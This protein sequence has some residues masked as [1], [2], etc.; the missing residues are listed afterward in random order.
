M[1][2]RE[3]TVIE[4]DVVDEIRTTWQDGSVTT[5]FSTTE[6]AER[7]RRARRRRLLAFRAN[8]GIAI[9]PRVKTAMDDLITQMLER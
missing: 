4:G 9:D 7:E 8:T 3:I 1:R 2:P 6:P 5:R